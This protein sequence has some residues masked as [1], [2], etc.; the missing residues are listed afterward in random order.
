MNSK[1]I[2][3]LFTSISICCF[4]SGC[5][6]KRMESSQTGMSL[7][8]IPSPAPSG[9][10]SPRV[11]SRSDGNVLLSWLEP[12]GDTASALRFSVWRTGTWSEPTT[13]VAAQPFSRHPSE[14]PGVVA[15]SDKNLIAYWS[16]K[17]PNAEK[18]TEEVDV[19]FA[20]S[21]DGGNHWTSP[22]LV[23]Q[24]G[25]GEENSYPSAAVVDNTHAALIWLDAANW[26]KQKRV[27]LMSRTVGSDGTMTEATVLD[28]D[29]CTCCP[30]SLVHSGSSLIAA[31]RGHTPG[32]IR[33]ISLLRNNQGRWSQPHVAHADNWHFA[34]CPVNGPHL[35]ADQK[36]TVI[37]W[38]TAAQDQPMVKLAFSSDG[39][40]SFANP[41]RVDE[42]NAIGRVQVV[43][44]PG[45]SAVAFWLE[46][47]LG[48]T[49]L[50]ARAV[51]E[52]GVIETPVEVSRGSHMA[53]PHA[54]SATDGILI[55]WSKGSPVRR[56][57]VGLFPFTS[58]E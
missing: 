10:F 29:T 27:A 24:S 18:G 52:D 2:V 45:H 57:H 39:G 26:K 15:L 20:L 14:S 40:T 5:H 51:H 36:R 31:Y 3:K 32:N 33:D 13:I 6:S 42:G 7:R 4:I 44:L 9:S 53:Y 55:A 1:T 23:N 54:A 11:T 34:G 38:F 49:R 47:L 56:V 30:T 8:E 46:H 35:D 41:I 16:Q 58:L 19:Y 48:T 21:T 43:L 22:V 37:S 17:L 28:E 25:T 12:Q 50:L